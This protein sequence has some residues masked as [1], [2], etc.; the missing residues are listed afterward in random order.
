MWLAGRYVCAAWDVDVLETMKDEIV[1]G[2]K[3]KVR[4][5]E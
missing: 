1:G 3:L 5:V 4:L 2:D